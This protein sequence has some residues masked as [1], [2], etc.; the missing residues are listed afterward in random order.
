MFSQGELFAG[1]A[2]S[3]GLTWIALALRM[4]A[5]LRV[6]GRLNVEDWLMIAAQ[7]SRHAHFFSIIR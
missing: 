3:L 7:V 4:V 5:R 6:L 2:V 1:L